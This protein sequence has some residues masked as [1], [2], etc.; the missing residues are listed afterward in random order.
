[1]E[2]PMDNHNKHYYEKDRE[3]FGEKAN[4][5]NNSFCIPSQFQEL[6]V[7]MYTTSD[8]NDEKKQEWAL[9]EKTFAVID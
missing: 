3:N 6:I 5:Q 4:P 2:K 7:R 9:I 1:M 8:I